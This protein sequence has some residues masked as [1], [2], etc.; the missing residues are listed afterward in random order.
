MEEHNEDFEF[1]FS[2][3]QGQNIDL[4]VINDPYDKPSHINTKK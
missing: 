2:S 1:S 4:G 3:C